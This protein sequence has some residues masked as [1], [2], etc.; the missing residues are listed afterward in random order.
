MP[1]DAVKRKTVM[2]D[3]TLPEIRSTLLKMSRLDILDLCWMLINVGA[4]MIEADVE[5]LDRMGKLPEG[6]AFILRAGSL[7][8][9]EACGRFK[10]T[11]CIVQRSLLEQPG[12]PELIKREGLCAVLEVRANSIG[13]IRHLE[14]IKALKNFEAVCCIRIIGLG[15]IDTPEW[16]ETM[17]YIKDVLGKEM[18]ICPDNRF[19]MGNA[20]ALEAAADGMEYVTTS[21]SGFGYGRSF[22]SLELVLPAMKLQRP[23]VRKVS[24]DVLPLLCEQFTKCSHV[25]IIKH[26]PALS[27]DSYS[28]RIIQYPDDYVEARELVDA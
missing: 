27:G 21:F 19:S 11:R 23:G 26:T 18:D 6:L 25:K 4:D 15:R 9:L 13:S 5:L 22:A 12:V 8:E 10:I 16:L 3:R 20:I 7:S 1:V 14:K 2:I 28:E 17:D 24:P